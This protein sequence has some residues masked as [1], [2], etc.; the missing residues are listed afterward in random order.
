[1]EPQDDVIAA[2][3][4]SDMASAAI[5]AAL[6]DKFAELG[7]LKSQD[8]GDVYDKALLMI[9]AQQGSSPI[10]RNVISAARKLLEKYLTPG[11][12]GFTSCR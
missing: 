1:M 10:S 12:D 2:I 11:P 9:E 3:A 8:V 5:L 4:A 6:V 7:V